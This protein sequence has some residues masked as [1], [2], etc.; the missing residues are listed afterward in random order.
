MRFAAAER[1][2]VELHPALLQL[3]LRAVETRLLADPQ[4]QVVASYPSIFLGREAEHVRRR[5]TE[6]VGGPPPESLVQFVTA[7]VTGTAARQGRRQ[8][9][10]FDYAADV[11]ARVVSEH[12][13]REFRCALCGY[14]FRRSDLGDE[15]R[16]VVEGEGGVF[17]TV[18][19]PGRSDD[20]YKPDVLT[21]LELDHLVPESGLGWTRP[22]NLRATCAFCNQTRQ[23]YRR[24]LESVSMAA[25]A[26]L[27]D[28]REG[29]SEST[30]RTFVAGAAIRHAHVCQ[31][32]DSTIVDVE[33]TARPRRGAHPLRLWFVP[34]IAEVMCYRCLASAE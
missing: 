14:H 34:W 21:R 25:V 24:P 20:P 2:G 17:A 3:V 10:P 22:D 16:D 8:P 29:Q 9:I 13:R 12:P 4:I 6:L 27:C 1:L 32:C 5:L 31:R 26:A 30:L 15:R 11:L 18:L 28:L 19:V 23:M 33:L 7:V